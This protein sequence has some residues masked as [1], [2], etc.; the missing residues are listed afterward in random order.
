MVECCCVDDMLPESADKVMEAAENITSTIC[1][2]NLLFVSEGSL[3]E[4]GRK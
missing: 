1:K 4:Q 3:S 2:K